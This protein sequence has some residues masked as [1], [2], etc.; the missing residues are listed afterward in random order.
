MKPYTASLIAMSFSVLAFGTGCGHDSS[1]T[2]RGDACPA[3]AVADPD[4]QQIVRGSS[5]DSYGED[6][7]AAGEFT[8][9]GTV[10]SREETWGCG[11]P[12][13][14]EFTLV[15]EPDSSP[16]QVRLC[17]DDGADPCEAGCRRELQWDLCQ[18]LADEDAS[19]IRVAD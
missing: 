10:I 12:E 4:V 3:E 8:R 7:S 6:I 1:A 9:D 14:P 15:Y 17:H 18:A 2:Q 19:G 16:L 11:C 5:C 13:R